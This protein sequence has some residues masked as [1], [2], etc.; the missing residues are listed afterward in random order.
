MPPRPNWG[1]SKAKTH[2]C[3]L[4]ETGELNPFELPDIK[5]L[6]ESDPELF[7]SFQ[8]KNFRQNVNNLAKKYQDKAPHLEGRVRH[9]NMEH[10]FNCN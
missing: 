5:I 9:T 2:L 3:T 6:H 10:R 8:L 4:F 7:G 1:K